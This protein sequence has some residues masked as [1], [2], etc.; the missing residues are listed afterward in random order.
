MTAQDDAREREMILMFNLSRPA[1]STRGGLDAQLDL[2]GTVVPFE[3]KST[4]RD[5][6]STVRDFGP[7]HIVKWKNLHWLFAFY[8]RNG[9]VLK[10]CYY[11]SPA[12]MADWISEKERYV[13]PDYVLAQRAPAKI[14]DEDLTAV[15]GVGGSFTVADARRIMKNQWNAKQY[16][17]NADLPGKMYS[18]AAMLKLLQ[19]RCEYVIRRGATLNNPHIPESYLSARVKPITKD[20]A[21]TVRVLVGEYLS[22][23]ELQLADGAMPLKDQLDPVIA[24][25]ARSAAATDEAIA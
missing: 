10:H 3:L 8:E 13:R 14:T 17:D 11:A 6:V 2:D 5:S 19:R 22:Q 9:T 20:H 7:E 21:A 18:R 12:D 1:D 15:V 23:R 25:Q 16:A 24:D 4:T